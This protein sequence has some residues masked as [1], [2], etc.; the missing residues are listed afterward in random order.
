MVDKNLPRMNH[1][2]ERFQRLAKD[3]QDA[4]ALLAIYDVP[5]AQILLAK[6]ANQLADIRTLAHPDAW[7]LLMKTDVAFMRELIHTNL[8]LVKLVVNEDAGLRVKFLAWLD[9]LDEDPGG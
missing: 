9:E 7:R 5:G 8:P 1:V 2:P 3:V 6:I 4:Q